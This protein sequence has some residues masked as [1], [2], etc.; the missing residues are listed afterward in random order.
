MFDTDSKTFITNHDSTISSKN[1]KKSRN[2]RS[3]DE[4][5]YMTV[6]NTAENPINVCA[7]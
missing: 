4:R 6:T 1:H 3:I 7:N 5:N 2:A